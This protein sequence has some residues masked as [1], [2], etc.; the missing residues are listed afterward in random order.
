[1]DGFAAAHVEKYTPLNLYPRL[2]DGRPAVP[3]LWLNRLRIASTSDAWTVLA[4][5]GYRHQF[6][7]GWKN[8][9]PER[10]LISTR[11]S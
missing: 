3:D 5:R 2:E 7:G 8:T 4:E 9:R 6:E 11:R 10:K 1:M